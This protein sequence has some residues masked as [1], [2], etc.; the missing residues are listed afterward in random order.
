MWSGLALW[1][2]A[3]GRAPG[4]VDMG[5]CHSSVGRVA[6]KHLLSELNTNLVLVRASPVLK[7]FKSGRCINLFKCMWC[8]CRRVD[9]VVSQAYPGMHYSCHWGEVVDICS[10]WLKRGASNFSDFIWQF[11]PPYM[12]VIP[13][14]KMAFIFPIS[15]IFALIF[16]RFMKYFPKCEGK[17]SFPKSQ[18]KSLNLAETIPPTNLWLFFYFTMSVY[19]GNHSPSSHYLLIPVHVWIPV[20]PILIDFRAGNQHPMSKRWIL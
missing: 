7:Y 5:I 15:C 8:G 12:G 6:V 9:Q 18:I 14:P 17:G 10:R 4:L 19:G 16:P 20:F 13:N 11:L 2:R 1:L 3:I